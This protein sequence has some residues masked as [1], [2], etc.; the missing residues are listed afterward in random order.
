MERFFRSL[1][2]ERLNYQSFAKSEYWKYEWWGRGWWDYWGILVWADRNR[3]LFL[4]YIICS[5]RKKWYLD[6]CCFLYVSP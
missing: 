5:R 4:H 1:K 3:K 2:T 6:P